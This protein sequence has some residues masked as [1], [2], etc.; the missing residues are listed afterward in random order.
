[1]SDRLPNFLL[2]GVPKSGTSSMHAYLRGHPDI[3]LP[4]RK[5]LHYFTHDL[6]AENLQ[7][8]GDQATW[9]RT[10]SSL[11]EYQSYYREAGSQKI[12]GESSPSY[13]FFHSILPNLRYMLGD[14]LRVLIMIR[15]PIRRAHSTYVHMV[16]NNRE[17]LTFHDA[18]LAETRRK[19]EGY[20]DF[21]RYAEHGL[22]FRPIEAYRDALGTGRV[23]VIVLE[24]FNHDNDRVLKD[25][26][27]WLGVRSDYRP[28]DLGAAY[29]HT[30]T[31]KNMAL[32]S[33]LSNAATLAVQVKKLVPTNLYARAKRFNARLNR[34]NTSRDQFP[35]EDRT[36]DHL[37]DFFRE[38]LQRT[39]ELLGKDLSSW[40]VRPSEGS[41]R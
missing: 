30:G 22:Y 35:L 34:A 12:V 10:V 29:G 31:A 28:H 3:Y 36:W 23:K 37:A 33:V 18:V 9:E 4:D 17:T 38:D 27:S 13:A 5:E 16:V 19:S 39:S 2:A 41:E 1:M 21:W 14:D 25:L 11:D 20:G 40:L 7:G 32:K 6:L 8:P 26:L 15:N 24:E